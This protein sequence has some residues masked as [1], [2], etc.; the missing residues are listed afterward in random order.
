MLDS[1]IFY[2]L[3]AVAIAS[4][5]LLVTRRNP[6]HSAVFLITTLLATAGIFLQLRAEFLFAMQLL[7]YA[8]GVGAL[9]LLVIVLVRQDVPF[10]TVRFSFQR[11]V[12]AFVGLALAME[13]AVTFLLLRQLPG[14][15]TL[16]LRTVPAE[17]LPPNS[18]AL[19]QMLFTSYLLPFE[20]TGVLL[21]VS[22]V[23]AV[24]LGKKGNAE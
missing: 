15:G 1:A 18:E 9:F 24:V 20:I 5:A 2:F 13:I 10:D 17:K 21:L 8:L 12:A 11:W 14:E 4:A 23:G 6:M 19:S 16:V 3:A 22:M 7:I